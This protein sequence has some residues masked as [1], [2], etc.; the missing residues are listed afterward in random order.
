[1]I[2]ELGQQLGD[3]SLIKSF[4]KEKA[5]EAKRELIVEQLQ[6]QNPK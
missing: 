3:V 2:N 6:L 5:E 4:C 1:M